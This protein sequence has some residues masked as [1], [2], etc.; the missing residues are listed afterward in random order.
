MTAMRRVR[1][2]RPGAAQ[3][4]FKTGT[5][6][7]VS[8]GARGCS[9]IRRDRRQR[10]RSRKSFTM[11]CGMT[12]NI[13]GIVDMVS[14]SFY[15]DQLPQ[16]AQRIERSDWSAGACQCV[17]G[18]V[19][20][21]SRTRNRLG[22]D[23][24]PVRR[25]QSPPPLRAAKNYRGAA[26]DAD[27]RQL[28]HQFADDIIARLSGGLP[29]IAQ[30]QIAFVSNRS[31]NKEIWEM[32]YDGA[33]QHQLTHLD[34]RAHAAVVAGRHA[35]RLYV[36]RALSRRH[37]GADL[38]VFHGLEPPDRVPAFRGTNSS[39]AW[40]PDGNNSRSWPA[41]AG[42]PEIFVTRRGRQHICTGSRFRAA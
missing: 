29:G 37:L 39:P 13:S 27:A 5:G 25:A 24:I 7:G 31:G 14:P 33:N 19:R 34:D 26:T 42:D 12:W 41:Q 4:W 1:P 10:S 21:L 16:P 38:H 23:R 30:T 22:R 3:D 40:S 20:Q 32:D 11:F 28:A 15:P 36:L 2:R 9:G 6:L 17:H 35:H 18:R 8:Q